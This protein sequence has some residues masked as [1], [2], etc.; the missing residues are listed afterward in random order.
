MKSYRA[1]RALAWKF[2]KNKDGVFSLIWALSL[3]VIV[4]CVG[5]AIDTIRYHHH[6]EKAQSITDAVA[7]SAAVFVKNNDRAPLSRKEG[8]LHNTPYSLDELG[9]NDPGNHEKKYKAKVRVIYDDV[10]RQARVTLEGELETYFMSI[11]GFEIL[12]MNVNS[13]VKYFEQ[14]VSPASVFLVLDNSGSMRWDDKPMTSNFS[15]PF[16]AQRRI[17]GLKSSVTD[18]NSTLAEKLR[19]GSNNAS[20]V[21]TGTYL[22]MAMIPYATD[23]IDSEKVPPAW[24]TL[25]QNKIDAMRDGG[26]TDSRKPL[27]EAEK[28]MSKEDRLHKAVNKSENPKKYVIF[29]TDGSNNSDTICDWRAKRRTRLWRKK[30]GNSYQYV[31]SR[32]SPGSGWQEGETFNCRTVNNSNI[33]SLKTCDALKALDVEVF[34]IGYA[35]EP[36]RY[37][38]DNGRYAPSQTTISKETTDAAYGF[39]SACASSPE[40]FI[41][42][43]NTEKLQK[44]FDDIGAKIIKDVIRIAS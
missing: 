28:W 14:E 44:A 29:M 42:A 36:G 41:K 13:D 22:R 37:Y 33:E 9:V 35:L 32:R 6:Q 24:K 43:E 39:L 23:I 31:R 26:G 17:D 27:E 16:G 2:G 38:V 18:F 40:H 4:M 8:F 21:S 25:P 3:L 7:L 10:T 20:T 30:N 11:F 5:A 19:N 1:I 34:T 15:R 12:D